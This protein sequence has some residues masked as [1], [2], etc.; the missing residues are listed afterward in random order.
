MAH[1][2]VTGSWIER[3]RGFEELDALHGQLMILQLFLTQTF[4]FVTLGFSDFLWTLPHFFGF[5]A[6]SLAISLL[7]F[8]SPSL[9]RSVCDAAYYSKLVA[10]PRPQRHVSHQLNYRGRQS[11]LLA[12]YL[13][14]TSLEFV[15]P[16]C[17]R[18]SPALVVCLLEVTKMSI[19]FF[20]RH[21]CRIDET[22]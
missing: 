10:A 9:P 1:F 4:V 15:C 19:I 3:L 14:P 12:L 17:R 21:F 11:Y 2:L 8:G 20:A 5:E 7:G 13:R 18:I 16:H 6:F 22:Q